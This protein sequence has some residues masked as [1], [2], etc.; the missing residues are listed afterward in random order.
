MAKV[1]QTFHISKYEAESCIF[2]NRL[3][4]AG[5]RRNCGVIVIYDCHG[6]RPALLWDDFV[7]FFC[8]VAEGGSVDDT[9]QEEEDGPEGVDGEGYGRVGP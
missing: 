7:G 5:T 1:V 4:T 6:Q 8:E 3:R 2:K 9:A